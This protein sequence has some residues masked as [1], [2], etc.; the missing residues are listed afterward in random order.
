MIG[1]RSGELG[2]EGQCDGCREFWPITAEFWPVKKRLV[3]LCRACYN[4]RLNPPVTGT[5]RNYRSR[6]G[7]MSYLNWRK[8]YNRTW[9]RAY[10]ARGAA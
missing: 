4:V 5:F 1:V 10:R 3:R 8:E 6:G 2:F 7:T 9:M